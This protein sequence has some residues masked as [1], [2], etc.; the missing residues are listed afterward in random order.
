MNCFTSPWSN[1]NNLFFLNFNGLAYCEFKEGVEFIAKSFPQSFREEKEVDGSVIVS[2]SFK[3]CNSNWRSH[4]KDRL[5]S[6]NSFISVQYAKDLKMSRNYKQSELTVVQF[7][8][9]KILFSE[10]SKHD[11][12]SDNDISNYFFFVEN[13]NI[14][15]LDFRPSGRYK[16]VTL[17]LV[18]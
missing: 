1:K 16:I 7:V 9:F 13:I 11:L 5:Y 6:N 14:N 12:L 3:F 2:K 15:S 10:I 8:A 17:Y 18:V 4:F